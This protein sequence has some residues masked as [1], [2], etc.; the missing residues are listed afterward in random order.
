MNMTAEHSRFAL[1]SNTLANL[2]GKV[3]I[4][5]SGVIL[6]PL[7]LRA[8]GN[9]AFGVITA[10]N[11]FNIILTLLDLGLSRSIQ[12][13]VA[14]SSLRR[15]G[16]T[17][18]SLF[19]IGEMCYWIL[20][21]FGYL[22]L[23]LISPYLASGWLRSSSISADEL[24]VII[25]LCCVQFLFS[26]PTSL[27]IGALSAL[28]KQ[29]A[30]NVA[31][32][33][34]ALVRV[35][36]GF[37]VLT[38]G[39]P[40]LTDFLRAN[41]FSTIFTCAILFT[42][43]RNQFDYQG[44]VRHVNVTLLPKLKLAGGIAVISLLNIVT[45]QADRLMATGMLTLDQLASL[46]IATS[47]S[48]IP[49]SLGTS[50]NSAIG[51]RYVHSAA[52]KSRKETATLYKNVTILSAAVIAS[53]SAVVIAFSPQLVD[54]WTDRHSLAT[55]TSSLIGLTVAGS[56][57]ATASYLIVSLQYA[58]GN[59]RIGSIVNLITL[60]TSPLVTYYG[61][62]SFGL[63]G[64][65]LGPIVSAAIQFALNHALTFK[66]ILQGEPQWDYYW[67]LISI[68]GVVGAVTSSAKAIVTIWPVAPSFL[69]AAII[70]V[71]L[72]NGISVLPILMRVPLVVGR[73]A[74][75]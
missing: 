41:L 69:P 61:I 72:L 54:I 2:L 37:Y 63:P 3:L 9:E 58:Y 12:V 16:K 57:L 64:A 65:A 60:A 52:T 66:S 14:R 19:S 43:A 31:L 67:T 70:T 53:I 55:Q 30:V 27:Y 32:S 10:C 56:A 29:V 46:G 17:H 45:S 34:G 49:V 20:A 13:D 48:L 44:I 39:T 4:T 38:R 42:L 75:T 23:W 74:R 68:V 62:L 71:V 33:L 36:V 59:T 24:T 51:P 21:L 1:L 47:F 6:T 40:A 18:S 15:E 8:F 28:E 35:C 26:F 73:Y 11:T 7:Q 22:M 5:L 25:R 50:I